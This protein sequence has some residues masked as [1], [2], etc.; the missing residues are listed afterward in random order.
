VDDIPLKCIA[1]LWLRRSRCSPLSVHIDY[2]LADSP[3]VFAT[4]LPHRARWEYIKLN[5]YA[6]LFS[7]IA[8]P[9]LLLR[10]LDLIFLNDGVEDL[11]APC[12][13]P[14][15]RTAILNHHAAA[16]MILP[17]AQ[18]TSLALNGLFP[19]QCVPILQQTPNLEHCEL[20]LFGDYFKTGDL[21]DV[22]LPCL[23]A[24][25]LK[26]KYR[27]VTNYLHTINT[28]ALQNLEIPEPFLGSNQID[29]LTLFI[30]KSGC[31]LREVRITSRRWIDQ[32]AYRAAFPSI[33]TFS[34]DSWYDNQ[35]A[36]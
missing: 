6:S 30:S 27:P 23:R 8:G 25:A 11:G 19:H 17:W 32:D 5:L 1:G 31:K 2:P 21:P 7:T 29:A 13:L 9:M 3:E 4:I 20:G 33:E 10:Q 22:V 35:V 16:T 34:F 36:E 14:L 18:L 12:E 28:P 15:L 24:L 26:Q